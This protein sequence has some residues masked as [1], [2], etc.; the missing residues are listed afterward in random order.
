[1]TRYHYAGTVVYSQ[2]HGTKGKGEKLTVETRRIYEH[3]LV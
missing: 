3:I 1:M 2:V